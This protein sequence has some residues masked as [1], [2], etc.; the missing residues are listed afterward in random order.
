MQVL[1]RFFGVYGKVDW[2][3]QGATVEG[4]VKLDAT[5]V[6]RL[7]SSD[8][9]ANK[10][11]RLLLRPGV[12]DRHRRLYGLSRVNAA[13]RAPASMGS[14]SKLKSDP[15]AGVGAPGGGGQ[16]Q[17]PTF[18]LDARLGDFK[19]SALNIQNPLDPGE[20][21]IDEKLSSRRA[22]RFSQLIQT[23]A[24]NLQS[25]FFYLEKEQKT[26]FSGGFS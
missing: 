2:E 25:V 4:L 18:D 22:K 8:P 1:S 21:L 14:D 10:G 26:E 23:G 3:K 5:G 15:S 19:L 24:R 16:Q 7:G 11:D 20:N 12:L 17:P 13:K 6:R 9:R